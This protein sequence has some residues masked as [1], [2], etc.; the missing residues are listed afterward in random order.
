MD[1][2]GR[3]P[4]HRFADYFP[5]HAHELVPHDGCRLLPPVAPPLDVP[6]VVTA[7]EALDADTLAVSLIDRASMVDTVL[8][9][10]PSGVADVVETIVLHRTD[11]V[12]IRF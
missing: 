10:L 6:L 2:T 4:H 9:S 7:V 12:L 8:G 1:R 3:Q 11:A 5:G